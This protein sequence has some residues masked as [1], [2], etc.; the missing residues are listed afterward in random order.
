MYGSKKARTVTENAYRLQP[1]V[2]GI[3]RR[4]RVIALEKDSNQGQI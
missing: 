2:Q 3:K 1:K 4:K